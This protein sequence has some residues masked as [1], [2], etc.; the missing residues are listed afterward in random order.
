[1]KK[2]NSPFCINLQ[3]SNLYE[4]E[5]GGGSNYANP[6]KTSGVS[7]TTA[8]TTAA[9]QA[10]DLLKFYQILSDTTVRRTEVDQ[11]DVKLY[12]KSDKR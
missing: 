12:W 5:V 11:E 7:S 2:L 3:N 8:S 1:M 9:Q 6:V 4:G 10:P